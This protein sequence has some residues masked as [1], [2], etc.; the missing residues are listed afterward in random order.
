MKKIFFWKK[1]FQYPTEQNRKKRKSWIK[2]VYQKFL[3]KI[4]HSFKILFCWCNKF[5][6]ISCF[7]FFTWLYTRRLFPIFSKLIGNLHK[8]Y[9]LEVTVNLS[10]FLKIWRGFKFFLMKKIF[11]GTSLPVPPSAAQN[12]ILP[13]LVTVKTVSKTETV[14]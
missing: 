12:L 2:R 13:S 8:G 1:I 4:F 5:V 6:F 3:K 11:V 14:S 9:T 10:D 7:T